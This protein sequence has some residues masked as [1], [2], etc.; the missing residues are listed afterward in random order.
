MKPEGEH[1]DIY[2]NQALR[3]GEDIA[4]SYFFKLHNKS[5]CYF[6]LNMIHNRLDVEDI[7]ADCFFKLWQRRK[8]FETAE[9]IKAFLYISCRNACLNY[10]NHQKVKTAFQEDY[11]R[12]LD[13]T[14]DSVLNKIIKSEV[15]QALNLEIELLPENY[16]I[17]FKLLYLDGKKT[18]EIALDLSLSVQTVRNYKARAIEL[19]KTAMLKKSISVTLVATLFAIFES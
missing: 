7:V 8:N 15:I 3:N 11:Y 2:W 10:L 13:Y 6:A 4:L 18:D 16:R 1:N 5:L 14:D 17:V 12:Y 9:N 19:L